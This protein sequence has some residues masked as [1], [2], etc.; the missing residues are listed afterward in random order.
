MMD[1]RHDQ[2]DEILARTWSPDSWRQFEAVQQ[3]RYPDD[4]AVASVVDRLSQLPPLV[5]SWEIESLKDLLARASAGEA[6]LLQGG[7]CSERIEECQ[8]D[9]IVRNLKVLIQMSFVLTAWDE[10]RGSMPSP[11][12]RIPRRGT[13]SRCRFIVATLSIAVPLHPRIA[14]RIRNC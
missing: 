14:S 6:F 10:L 8:T 11:D 2:I 3:P 7:D 9:A 12:P 5:T 13:G 1:Q 4:T